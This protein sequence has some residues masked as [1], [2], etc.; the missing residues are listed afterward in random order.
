[1][2][3][4][5]KPDQKDNNRQS[6]NNRCEQVR[7]L[8]STNDRLLEDVFESIQDGICVVDT[9]LIIRRVNGVMN[10]WYAEHV[11]LEGNKCHI[12]YHNSD[13]PC[14][15]CPA[16]RCFQSGK[17]EREI[18]AG[19]AGSTVKW[20]EV[21][22]FPIKDR[23][24]GAVSGA[25]EYVRDIT[26]R[27]DAEK[28]IQA[29]EKQYRDLFDNA[30]EL[31]QCVN[32]DGRFLRVNTKW[33]EI[34]GFSEEDAANLS[35]WDIIHPDEI[36][37]CQEVFTKIFSGK[38]V[39]VMETTFLAKDGTAIP[40]EGT[41]NCRFSGGKPTST[42]AVFRDVR[43]RKQAEEEKTKLKAQLSR[44]EKL[45]AIGTLAGGIAH[46]FNNL[47]MTIQGNASLMLYDLDTSHSYF[48]TLKNIENAVKSGAKLT[49]QLLGYARKGKYDVKP[50]CLNEII[51]ETIDAFSRA[52][53]EISVH[54]QLKKDLSS[55]DAD[56]GQMEQV[57]LNLFVN[58]SDAMPGGGDLILH[59]SNVTDEAMRGRLYS[60][61]I[62]NYVKLTVADTG[63]GMDKDT[64]ERIFDPFFT[65][66]EMGRGT[67]LGLASVY[68][69]IKSHGGYIDVESEEGQGTTFS[70]FLPA[71][72]KKRD[73]KIDSKNRIIEGSGNILLV[74]D[75]EMVL[76]IGAKL[77]KKVGYRVF[78]AKSGREAVDV[79]KENKAKIDL[80][81]LDMIM[82]E[83]GG[84][85]VYDKM[86]RIDSNV[87]VLL[88]SGYSING[89]ATEIL[90]R[91]CNGFIQKPFN[92]KDIS[93]KINEILGN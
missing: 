74:D 51:T 40:M 12:S 65:S 18:I 36:P 47:L 88:S 80:V 68:G 59:T 23:D 76:E 89:E 32:S 70:I 1:M 82:P 38:K 35:V 20:I 6:S 25:V 52:R 7:D 57:L 34:L 55:I 46:D 13:K 50:I 64:Q 28:A 75:E 61:K 69:I 26:Q 8:L 2:A 79:Y 42:L 21:F 92:M 71:S 44:V 29:S 53:K 58:A 67:G 77:I 48:E 31:I 43:E 73:E 24:S 54:C 86:K 85:E 81:I 27:M 84:G 4:Y 90:K 62:G 41:A 87:R 39:G 91:G 11:P 17:T 9:N 10:K 49:K 5:K 63:I 56:Q 19:P 60:P 72:D 33:K 45:E 15:F 37:H 93:E 14:K 66:K 83:M 16:L 3:I 22:S 30:N 78:E